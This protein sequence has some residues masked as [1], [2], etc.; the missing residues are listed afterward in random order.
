MRKYTILLMLFVSLVQ[1]NA[2]KTSLGLFT[3]GAIYRGDIS[4]TDPFATNG[5]NGAIGL[6]LEHEVN[7]GFFISGNIITGKV[8]GN[9]MDIEERKN[10]NKLSFSS[11]LTEATLNFEW[12]ILGSDLESPEREVPR[13]FSNRISPYLFAGVGVVIVDA[14]VQGLPSDAPEVFEGSDMGTYLSIPFGLG[15]KYNVSNLVSFDLEAGLRFPTTDL[16]DGISQ[17]RNP[18]FNDVFSVFGLAINYRLGAK[19]ARNDQKEFDE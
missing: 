8:T 16:L 19:K 13:L 2:Q 1:L 12:H 15:I 18:D 17:S 10:W 7:A 9:D 5:M 4:P 3:G 6:Q 14:S 11:I